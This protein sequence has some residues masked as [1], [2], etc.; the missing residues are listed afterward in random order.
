MAS[1]KAMGRLS[2]FGRGR[3]IGHCNV[4]KLLFRACSR[5]MNLP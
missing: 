4:I 1:N 5:M 3:C 2:H